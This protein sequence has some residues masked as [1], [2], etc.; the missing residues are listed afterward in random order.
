MAVRVEVE[1]A[2]LEWAAERSRL[3][4]GVLVGRFPKLP[5]WEQRETL[6]TLKQ[7]ENYAHAT[8]T[9]LGFLLLD[10][11]P[12]DVVPIEDFRTMGDHRVIAP[13][14]NLLDSVYACQQ[15]QDW[16]RDFARLNG[17]DPLRFVGSL[18]LNVGIEEAAGAVA[19]ALSFQLVDRRQIGSWTA[20]LDHLRERAEAIG[21]LVMISGVVG[22]DGH[23]KLD[24]AEFRG[25]ALVDDLAPVVFVNGA[26]TK[27]AQ[28]FTLVHEL[29][30]I[31][32]GRTGVSDVDLGAQSSDPVERWCNQVAAEVLVPSAEIRNE[33][34]DAHNPVPHFDRIAKRFKVSTLVVLRRLFEVGK[35]E[36]PTYRRIYAAELARVLAL[37]AEGR[38]STGGDFYNTN[39]VRVSKR[40]ARALIAS[41]WEGH[42][43]YRDATRLLGFKKL[44]TLDTLGQKLGVV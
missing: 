31:W 7:L 36:W 29:A 19:E 24:P 43:L 22:S 34:F 2:L 3:D 44:S 15:R 10:S 26:D 27:A 23:R 28:I 14:V 9:P 33:P 18:D 5:E 21:V 1:P 41:T 4:R 35:L 16:Y 12:V 11:A 30:H 42:T 37:A 13:S 40:F 39:P 20:A 8:H 25:F 38:K 6:P 32:L 17:D